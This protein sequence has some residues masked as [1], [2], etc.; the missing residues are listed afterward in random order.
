MQYNPIDVIVF[1][2]NIIIYNKKYKYYKTP[3]S[4]SKFNLSQFECLRILLKYI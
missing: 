1:C 2:E 3:I 4:Q